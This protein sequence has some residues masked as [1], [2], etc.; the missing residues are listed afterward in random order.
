MLLK[1]SK[2]W[3]GLLDTQKSL[4]SLCCFSSSLY[5]DSEG[6]KPDTPVRPEMGIKTLRPKLLEQ[7]LSGLGRIS[8][9]C[10][11]EDK[12]PWSTKGPFIFCAQRQVPAPTLLSQPLCPPTPNPDTQSPEKPIPITR[13][14]SDIATG[15][16]LET[17]RQTNMVSGVSWEIKVGELV[18]S[19][20]LDSISLSFSSLYS[21]FGF[22]VGFGKVFRKQLFVIKVKTILESIRIG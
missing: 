5:L 22:D 11:P 19:P 8:L 17:S 20:S 7:P 18:Q 10:G 1:H 4:A 16:A 14:L 15:V 9:L 21:G 6:W 2:R 12:P 13:H 3:Q